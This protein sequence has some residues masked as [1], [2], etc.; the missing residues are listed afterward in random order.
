MKLS[1][2]IANLCLTAVP[3]SCVHIRVSALSPFLNDKGYVCSRAFLNSEG[4]GAPGTATLRQGAAAV[5]LAATRWQPVQSWAG[6]GRA[7]S[8][9]TFP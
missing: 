1:R 2:V 4:Q 6:G 9:L 3:I 5:P 7:L 8:P